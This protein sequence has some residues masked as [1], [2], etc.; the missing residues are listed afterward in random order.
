MAQAK[1]PQKEGE[2]SGP[3]SAEQAQG[4]VTR[5]QASPGDG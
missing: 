2:P 5:W 1:K 3:M 4:L